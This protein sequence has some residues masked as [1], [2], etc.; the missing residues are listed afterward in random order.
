MRYACDGLNAFDL[1]DAR[2]REAALE[3][4]DLLWTLEDGNALPQCPANPHGRAMRVPKLSLRPCEYEVQRLLVWSL[5]RRD[6][7][8]GN[9]QRLPQDLPPEA[10]RDALQEQKA[11]WV[12]RQLFTPQEAAL[13]RP[14]DLLRFYTGPLGRRLLASPLVKR[15]WSFNF[16]LSHEKET[17][18]QGVMDCAFRE[19]DG[20]VLLDYKT[21]RVEDPAAFVA[22]YAPQ[23]RLYAQALGEITALPVREMWLYAV[24]NG[25]AYPVPP[26]DAPETEPGRFAGI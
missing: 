24:G 20:W 5:E 23:L 11:A 3:G 10:W 4:R 16:R 26:G 8:S 9:L 17:L 1:H 15:E 14:E 21:D 12:S 6:P 2:V 22:R 25:Q 7:E 18:L 19:G 13:L